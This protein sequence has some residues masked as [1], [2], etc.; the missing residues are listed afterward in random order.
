M[1]SLTLHRGDITQH[2]VDAIVN[3]ANSSLQ[4]GGGVDG[5]IHRRAGPALSEEQR[6]NE[7]PEHM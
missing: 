5:A 6:R 2:D 3:A 7:A 1:S 4:G